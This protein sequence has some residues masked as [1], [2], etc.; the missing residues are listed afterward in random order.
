MAENTTIIRIPASEETFLIYWL[1]FLK[2][3]HK[4]TDTE[5]KVAVEFI[6]ER[7]AL[8]K[9][10]TDEALIDKVLMQEDTRNKIRDNLKITPKHYYLIMHSLNKKK[11]INNGV[12]NVK[13]IPNIEENAKDF[14]LTFYFDLN[15]K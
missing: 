6:K 14:R 7:Y 2:P 8:G 4:M 12:F 1:E 5:I 13:F 3:F 15:K 9:V 11:V 10:I